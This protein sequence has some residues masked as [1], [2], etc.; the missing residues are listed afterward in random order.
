MTSDKNKKRNFKAKKINKV[1]KFSF[2]K[3]VCHSYYFALVLF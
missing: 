2:G 1:A 3:Y